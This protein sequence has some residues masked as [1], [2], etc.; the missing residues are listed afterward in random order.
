MHKTA[1]IIKLAKKR[2]RRREGGWVSGRRWQFCH[3]NVEEEMGGR[4]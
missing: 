2:G 4:E 1:P 3:E